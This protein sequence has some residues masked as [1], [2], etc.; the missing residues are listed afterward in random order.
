MDNLGPIGGV[1][2]AKVPV[3][4]IVSQAGEMV[5]HAVHVVRC[6][7]YENYEVDKADQRNRCQQ[8]GK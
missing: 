7:G 1:V 6:G 4:E 2:V 5:I 3:L 8:D